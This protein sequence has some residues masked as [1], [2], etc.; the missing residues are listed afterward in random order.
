MGESQ[1]AVMLGAA[2]VASLVPARAGGAVEPA[3]AL[4]PEKQ[5]WRPGAQTLG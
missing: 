3:V 4:R 5:D 1:V 2:V